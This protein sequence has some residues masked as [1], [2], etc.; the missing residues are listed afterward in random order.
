MTTPHVK[1]RGRVLTDSAGAELATAA[2]P[3]MS[4]VVGTVADNDPNTAANNPVAIGAIAASSK[5]TFTAGDIGTLRMDT[6]SNLYVTIGAQDSGGQLTDSE[7]VAVQTGL[8][9]TR[10]YYTNGTTGILSNTT[11]AVTIKTAAGASV[12]NYIDGL[13]IATTAFGASVPVAIRDGAGG[14]VIW[15]ANVP[16]AGLLTPVVIRFPV[17]LRST[18]NTL[19]EIVTPTANTSGTVWVNVQGHTGA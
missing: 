15:S 7:G 1:S 16:T 11:T 6:R 9:S 5:P 12:R 17:P 14:T 10:W 2:N 3:L 8:S 13:Q 19:L 18:A 4:E